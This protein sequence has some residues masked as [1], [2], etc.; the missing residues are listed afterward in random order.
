MSEADVFVALL[1]GRETTIGG[2]HYCR[3]PV[4]GRGS[5]GIREGRKG[6]VLHCLSHCSRDNIMFAIR[7]LGDRQNEAAARGTAKAVPLTHEQSIAATAIEDAIASG[8][9]VLR[10]EDFRLTDLRTRSLW[11][12]KARM[13]PHAWTERAR[14]GDQ[15]RSMSNYPT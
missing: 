2:W 4:C 15:W 11:E 10:Y 5:L 9:R 6:T 3:C 7:K 12:G 13:V 14:K 8:Q 1:G